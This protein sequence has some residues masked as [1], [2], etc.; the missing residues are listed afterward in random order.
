MSL[1]EVPF[2]SKIDLGPPGTALKSKDR[3][4]TILKSLKM[5]GSSNNQF[6][7]VVFFIFL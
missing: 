7:S 4:L 2:S 6:P 3:A 5:Q 1:Y